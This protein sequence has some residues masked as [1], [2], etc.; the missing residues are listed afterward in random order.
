MSSGASEDVVAE[1]FNLS[2]CVHRVVSLYNALAHT[3]THSN[4]I[5]DN[6]FKVVL[7]RPDNAI[8]SGTGMLDTY[9]VS[10]ASTLLNTASRAPPAL[11][12]VYV[13]E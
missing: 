6:A 1:L 9:L 13:P 3:V 5:V 8:M 7:V 2:F 4:S 12:S 11:S 10:H